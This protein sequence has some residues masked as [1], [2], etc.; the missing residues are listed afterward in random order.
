MNLF[1]YNEFWKPHVRDCHTRTHHIY[2]KYFGLFVRIPVFIFN[3]L[4][5]V[6][7]SNGHRQQ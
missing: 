5:K 2:A 3:I 4:E 6:D 7:F 1:F